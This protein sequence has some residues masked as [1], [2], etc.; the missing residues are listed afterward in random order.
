MRFPWYYF[1]GGVKFAIGTERYRISFVRPNDREDISLRLAARS[2]NG[3]PEALAVT[4]RK[5]E[6]ICKGRRTGRA[7]KAVFLER[8]SSNELR[9]RSV[10]DGT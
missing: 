10:T 3:G 7:W 4:V 5:I 2:R 6:D 8:K 1:G 9:R